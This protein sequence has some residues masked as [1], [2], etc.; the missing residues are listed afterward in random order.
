VRLRWI[1]LLSTLLFIVALTFAW[2]RQDHSH[3]GKISWWP[4][5]RGIVRPF[6]MLANVA[7]YWPLG[8]MLP[9]RARRRRLIVAMF[10]AATVSISLEL[11]QV[12]SHVRIP[13]LVDVVMNMI[14]ALTGAAMGKRSGPESIKA[15]E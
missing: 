15:T 1:G 10:V 6:D 9:V 5:G 2:D 14:G 8:F 7:L 13:S 4:L 11:S 3:W 12:W